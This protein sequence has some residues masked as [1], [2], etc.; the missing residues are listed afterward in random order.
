MLGDILRS[1]TTTSR[2]RCGWSTRRAGTREEDEHG[3]L[4]PDSWQLGRWTLN[5]AS[6][7]ALVMSIPA[8]GAATGTWRPARGSRRR[9]ASS[10]GTQCRRGLASWDMFGDGRTA[11]KGSVS[12]YD[13]LEGVTVSSRSTSATSR[14]D[15]PGP[16]TTT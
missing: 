1:R 2:T 16:T 12:R 5:R 9:T 14:S 8:R 3:A 4:R 11:L 10:T 13:R 6:L 7:R 15:L